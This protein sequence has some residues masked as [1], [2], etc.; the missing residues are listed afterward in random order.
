M[1]TPSISFFSIFSSIYKYKIKKCLLNTV[2][3]LALIYDSRIKLLYVF[4]FAMNQI[5]I[6]FYKNALWKSQQKIGDINNAFCSSHSF[7]IDIKSNSIR[8]HH[9]HHIYL[10]NRNCKSEILKRLKFLK[11]EG[12]LKSISSLL[13][14]AVSTSVGE[15]FS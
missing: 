12:E 15:K 13:T 2:I 4:L 14:P 3:R 5:R 9:V 6:D 11:V 1:Y 7:T 10:S 8:P